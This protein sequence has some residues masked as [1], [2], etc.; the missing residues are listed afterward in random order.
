MGEPGLNLIGEGERYGMIGK[1]LLEFIENFNKHFTIKIASKVIWFL[2][3]A[4][5]EELK[6]GEDGSDIDLEK[7]KKKVEGC[8]SISKKVWDGKE[9]I[10][11]YIV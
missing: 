3:Y 9:E 1:I 6:N 8:Q 10:S 4:L 5:V 11:I 2:N 7:V